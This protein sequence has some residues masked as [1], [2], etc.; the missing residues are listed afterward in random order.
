MSVRRSLMLRFVL[1]AG[2]V[3]MFFGILGIYS[4]PSAFSANSGSSSALSTYEET[5]REQRQ[6][7][8]EE[9]ERTMEAVEEDIRV[10]EEKIGDKHR[11]VSVASQDLREV[12]RDIEEVAAALIETERSID[13]LSADLETTKRALHQQEV[14]I[15]ERRAVLR[16]TLQSV[17]EY[18]RV[19]IVEILLRE[20]SISGFFDALVRFQSIQQSLQDALQELRR[21]RDVLLDFRDR[22]EQEQRELTERNELQ[23]TQRVHL[24]QRRLE[25]T[26]TI[27]EADAQA[28]K[29]E[30]LV[31]D[32]ERAKE[33]IQQ[34]I[35]RLQF[36]GVEQNFSLDD[37]KVLA[38]TVGDAF[39]LRPAFIMAMLKQESN[40]GQNTGTAHYLDAYTC[41]GQHDANDEYIASQIGEFFA[42][43][44][45][46][47]RD[48]ETTL[49]SACPGYGTGGAMGPA[50]FMPLTWK[51]YANEVSAVTGH[52]PADPWNLADAMAAMGLKLSR[53]GAVAG[54]R[55]SEFNAAL[56]YFSG[57]V[58]HKYDWYAE[59]VL[60]LADAYE[61]EF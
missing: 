10:Y 25:Y 60:E 7:E 20:R 22:Q 32:A 39:G 34:R 57:G 38:T 30:Q 17:D 9:Y 11:E 40:F 35:Y 48:P 36:A 4:V 58:H 31:V 23:K 28:A 47:G 41:N 27:A 15:E 46:L 13:E 18:E 26:S 12:E 21:Q 49:V 50:Q 1:C 8:K 16:A 29:Y 14:I 56:I 33:E 24:A 6:R 2:R 42:I 59:S 51:G 53:N 54:D 3:V 19:S 52:T 44:D 43:V 55:T 5:L 61:K 37:V 45:A